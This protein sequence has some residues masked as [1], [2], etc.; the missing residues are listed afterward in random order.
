MPASDEALGL[1]LVAEDR[2]SARFVANLIERAMKGKDVRPWIWRETKRSQAVDARLCYVRPKDIKSVAD[3]LNLQASK[4][5][6]QNGLARQL[7]QST[8]IARHLGSRAV[9]FAI[10]NDKKD[11]LLRS[12]LDEARKEVGEVVGEMVSVVLSVALPEIEAWIIIDARERV[13]PKVL[14]EHRRRLGFDPTREAHRLVSSP[15]DAEHECKRVF[16]ALELEA[17]A[18]DAPLSTLDELKEWGKETGLSALIEEVD[19]RLVPLLK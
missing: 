13:P 2:T 12:T 6:A 16:K 9:V 7:H 17:E 15:P 8:L 19:E 1:L 5:K 4:L 18:H 10:D 3:E 14:D 11:K